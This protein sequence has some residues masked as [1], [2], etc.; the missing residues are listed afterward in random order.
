MHKPGLHID[1][2]EQVY[3]LKYWAVWHALQHAL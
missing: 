2:M 1:S 3:N